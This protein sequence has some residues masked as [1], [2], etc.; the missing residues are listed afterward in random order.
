MGGRGGGGCDAAAAALPDSDPP[1]GTGCDAL[2]PK[3]KLHGSQGR[4]CNNDAREAGLAMF[5]RS[6]VGRAGKRGTR[7]GQVRGYKSESMAR[8]WRW[9]A[10][11]FW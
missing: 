11:C 3:F 2:H 6:A 1:A 5:S 4:A 9:P 8:D 10:H 7:G